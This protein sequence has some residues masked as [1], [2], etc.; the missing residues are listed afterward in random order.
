MNANVGPLQCLSYLIAILDKKI[1]QIRPLNE[2][3]I[4]VRAPLL[5]TCDEIG[6]RVS[7]AQNTGNKQVDKTFVFDKVC[8]G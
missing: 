1:D 3:E 4:K 6:R 5:I 7:A 8:F 2:D